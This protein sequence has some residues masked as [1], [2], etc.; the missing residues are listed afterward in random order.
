MRVGTC[1]CL[2]TSAN[3]IKKFSEPEEGALVF[4]GGNPPA[5]MGKRELGIAVATAAAQ[6]RNRMLAVVA[7]RGNES[8]QGPSPLLLADPAMAFL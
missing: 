3:L 7:R 8:I 1:A 2:S 5:R 4:V 6:R